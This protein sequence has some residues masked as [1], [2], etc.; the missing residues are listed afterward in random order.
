M[1][2]PKLSPA[3]VDQGMDA[4]VASDPS[5]FEGDR[6]APKILRRPIGPA[7]VGDHDA[8]PGRTVRLVLHR[9]L[10]PAIDGQPDHQASLIVLM[11]RLER[12]VGF[13]REIAADRSQQARPMIDTEAVMGSLPEIRAGGG[14]DDKPFRRQAPDFRFTGP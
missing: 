10:E 7:A 13:H 14:G 2:N 11:D 4:V 1:A 6:V 3:A 12:N 9:S 5:D 8:K